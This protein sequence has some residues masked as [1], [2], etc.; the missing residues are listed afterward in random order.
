[1]E[2]IEFVEFFGLI[3]LVELNKLILYGYFSCLPSGYIPF[4]HFIHCVL[5]LWT[6]KS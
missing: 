1:M 5:A 6:L 2:F 3:K 4:W